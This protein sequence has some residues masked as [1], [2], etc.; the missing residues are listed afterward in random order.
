MGRGSS[1]WRLIR[2]GTCAGLTH[3]SPPSLFMQAAGLQFAMLAPDQVS[4]AFPRL[5]PPSGTATLYT[6]A[7]GVVQGQ[8][9][10]AVL[11]AMAQRAGADVASGGTGG[12]GERC[13]L[14]WRD[15][16]SHFALRT[17]TADSAAAGVA[18]G[19][20][21]AAAAAGSE[22]ETIYEAEQLVLLPEAGV[23]RQALALFGLRL[24][25]AALWGVPAASW[26]AQEECA[27][28][29]LWQLLGSGSTRPVDDPTAID[30]CWGAPLLSWSPGG[31]LVGQSLADG[32]PLEPPPE[33]P[34]DAADA[35]SGGTSAAEAAA[36][37]AAAAAAAAAS[38]AG[39]AAAVAA[40]AAAV[41]EVALEE[42]PDSEEAI[43][44]Q[45]QRLKAEQQQAAAAER[46]LDTAGSLATR[47]VYGVGGRLAGSASQLRCIV[48]ADG[49]SAAGSHPGYEA[50]RLVVA[51][52]AAGRQR[53]CLPA[54]QLAPLVARLALA[55]L[56]GSA[57]EAVDAAAVA[58]GRQALGAEAAELR[59]DTWAELGRAP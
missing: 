39:D 22:G 56:Q 31:V 55:A 15:A 7:G 11:R 36:A 42:R 29:P 35:G 46:R 32:V 54:D 51:F 34:A 44:A 9:A 38:S 37:R 25:G 26:A 57:P 1:A 23:Q 17:G 40:A 47:L 24:P 52:P 33:P 43:D 3:C 2:C 6:P 8:V 49:E 48:T 50:G 19:A 20:R 21:A 58:L 5:R 13:L 10:A 59:H 53:G 27:G 30:A 16:G 45:L 12:S 14:G 41:A 28:V 4:A 18:A